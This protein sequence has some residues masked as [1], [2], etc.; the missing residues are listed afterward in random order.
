MQ[1]AA[2]AVSLAAILE[3]DTAAATTTTGAADATNKLE[4]RML[5]VAAPVASVALEVTNPA[6]VVEVVGVELNWMNVELMVAGSNGPELLEEELLEAGC[7]NDECLEG[8]AVAVLTDDN[9]VEKSRFEE[10]K[11]GI[12]R[13]LLLL[14]FAEVVMEESWVVDEMFEVLKEVFQLLR[15]SKLE[16]LGTLAIE[17]EMLNFTRV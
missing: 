7:P 17:L 2:I 9:V 1:F 11:L 12:G 6:K 5:G 16:P 4:T 3:A 14:I 15:A 10:S 13:L 8:G